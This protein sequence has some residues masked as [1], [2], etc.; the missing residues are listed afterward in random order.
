MNIGE[1]KKLIADLDDSME[2]G[3]SGHFG[4]FLECCDVYVTTVH[5]PKPGTRGYSRD[6]EQVKILQIS[7]ESPGTEPD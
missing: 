6:Y 3:G 5:K 1:L 2:L 7:I 4:E